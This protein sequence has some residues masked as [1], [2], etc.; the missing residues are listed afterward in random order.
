MNISENSS[1]E[2][3]RSLL[4]KLVQGEISFAYGLSKPNVDGDPASVETRA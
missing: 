2:Q 1:D 4:L 3:K